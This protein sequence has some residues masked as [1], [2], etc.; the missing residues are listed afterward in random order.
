MEPFAPRIVDSSSDVSAVIGGFNREFKLFNNDTVVYVLDRLILLQR[1]GIIA[2][3]KHQKVLHMKTEWSALH[4]SN[5]L[6]C[7]NIRKGPA[8]IS[9][10]FLSAPLGHSSSNW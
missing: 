1:L 5:Q 6:G 3:S 9:F 2:S 10:A 7:E 4:S 8:S